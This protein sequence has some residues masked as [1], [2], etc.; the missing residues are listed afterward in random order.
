MQTLWRAWS[1]HGGDRTL[2]FCCSIAHAN[3]VRAW[4]RGQGVKVAAVHAGEGS[5][6]RERSLSALE[7][8]ELGAV[9]AVDI[10]NEGVDVPSIDR[11]VMLRPTESSLLFLQQ[12]G[13][14]LRASPGKTAVNV[15]DFVGNHRMFLERLRALLSLGTGRGAERLR[16]LLEP[17]GTAELPAGCTRP[18]RPPTPDRSSSR[19]NGART[20]TSP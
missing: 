12:L 10:F 6:D 19:T 14:G 5:D 18:M 8:G 4:L 7:R 13:R 16:A 15:I 9:C 17:E 1:S 2:V 20:R 3:Y 11:V